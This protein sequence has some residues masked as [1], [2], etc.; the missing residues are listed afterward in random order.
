MGPFLLSA[1]TNLA[2]NLCMIFGEF[3]KYNYYKATFHCIGTPVIMVIGIAVICHYFRGHFLGTFRAICF[4]R[5]I[6]NILNLKKMAV[7][8]KSVSCITMVCNSNSNLNFD[9]TAIPM[10]DNIEND[11]GI[12]FRNQESIY[13][14]VRSTKG[15][16]HFW[17]KWSFGVNMILR[18]PGTY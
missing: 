14:G 7:L 8:K 12:T 10:H 1:K 15:Y 18:T 16:L 3:W 4:T 6:R 11:T 5:M 2:M 17:P 13:R 9:R